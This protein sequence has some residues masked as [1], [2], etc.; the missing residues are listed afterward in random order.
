MG[1]NHVQIGIGRH[2]RHGGLD[3]GVIRNQRIGIARAAR[4]AVGLSVH[5]KP[6]IDPA[7][8]VGIKEPWK[9]GLDPRPEWLLARMGRLP[10]PRQKAERRAA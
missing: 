4:L 10:A 9:P 2:P 1:H 3:A 8:V 5:G 6:V 7:D